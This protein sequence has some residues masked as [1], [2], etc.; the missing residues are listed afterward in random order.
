MHAEDGCAKN[1]QWD[2]SALES[3][4]C[5]HSQPSSARRS[6]CGPSFLPPHSP[7]RSLFSSLLSH[8]LSPPLSSPLLSSPPSSLLSPLLSS[9]LLSSL[10]P[11]LSSF[12]ICPLSSLLSS[13]LL[14]PCRRLISSLTQATSF[15]GGL[16][17]DPFAR[18]N[19]AS[20]GHH[21]GSCLGDLIA[22]SF[23][24]AHSDPL[25]QRKIAP[26]PPPL[27]ALSMHSS[28]PPTPPH[29]PPI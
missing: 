22:S 11:P 8:L 19:L 10:I 27:P 12:P 18:A 13:P 21:H 23:S 14:F 16:P 5:L 20:F 7:L 15:R 9:P 28:R 24:P 17:L 4:T 2:E 29:T 1:L 3:S 25:S 6:L 26:S